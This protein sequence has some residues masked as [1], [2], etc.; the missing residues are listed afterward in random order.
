IV[1]G[2]DHPICNKDGK[3]IQIRGNA[4]RMSGNSEY[5]GSE[6]GIV[7]V[8]VDENTNGLPDDTWYELKGS[9]YS[10]PST[11]HHHTYTYTRAQDTIRNPFHTQPYYPQWIE[12]D[13]ITFHGALLAPITT[14]INGQYVQRL[15]EWGYADNQ[16]NTD[17]E[18]TSFDLSW[19]VDTN[20]QSVQLTQI[21]FVRVYTAVQETYTQTGE[22]S[23]E[24]TGAVDLHAQ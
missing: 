7:M 4:F 14:Q 24:I 8:S 16:P 13:S 18:A 12:E 20:G 17:I 21:D 11:I 22:L 2:F 19:A 6:P 5:G 15:L 23:T 3:Y 9:M 10:H 1:F